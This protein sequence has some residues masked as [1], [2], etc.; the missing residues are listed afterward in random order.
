MTQTISLATIKTLRIVANEIRRVI[1]KSSGFYVSHGLSMPMIC[2]TKRKNIALI[3][4]LV[5]Y[6]VSGQYF[7]EHCKWF[8]CDR[9]QYDDV[10][11][12]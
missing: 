7:N 6:A 3:D 4:C 12:L 8:H 2:G 1:T 11:F 9:G 10:C 5:F